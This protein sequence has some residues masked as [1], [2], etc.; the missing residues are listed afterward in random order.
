MVL[1]SV[2]ALGGRYLRLFDACVCECDPGFHG[3]ICGATTPTPHPVTTPTMTMATTTEAP[4]TAN[5]SGGGGG[6]VT[7][8]V[9]ASVFVVAVAAVLFIRRRRSGPGNEFERVEGREG[10]D[11]AYASALTSQE[12]SR[13]VRIGGVVE[14]GVDYAV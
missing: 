11:M 8:V 12:H 6:V 10:T 9:V 4:P 3:P 5:S 7:A 2:C 1:V 14:E 13:A